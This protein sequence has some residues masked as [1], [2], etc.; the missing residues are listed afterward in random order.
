MVAI[1]SLGNY[2]SV[3]VCIISVLAQ[4]IA[5]PT[6]LVSRVP[7]FQSSKDAFH[8]FAN[9]GSPRREDNRRHRLCAI[10]RVPRGRFVGSEKIAILRLYFSESNRAPETDCTPFRAAPLMAAQGSTG[11]ND[12]TYASSLCGRSFQ[13]SRIREKVALARD[14]RIAALVA[15]VTSAWATREKSR[16]G[17]TIHP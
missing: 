13:R 2:S 15:L 6:K 3:D 9:S 17:S 10:L 5:L 11:S 8:P 12:H 1:F 7:D 4:S 14:N 16:R